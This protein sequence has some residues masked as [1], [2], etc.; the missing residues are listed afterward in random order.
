MRL[1][2]CKCG[3]T[4]KMIMKIPKKHEL[5]RVICEKCGEKTD[6]FMAEYQAE[7]VWNRLM[8]TYNC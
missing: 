8:R 5:C 4:P 2:K 7:A 3:A 6:L 1:N